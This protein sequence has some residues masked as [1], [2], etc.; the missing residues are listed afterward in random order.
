M[1]DPDNFPRICS[2]GYEEAVVPGW[3]IVEFPALSNTRTLAVIPDYQIVLIMKHILLVFFFFFSSYAF[4]QKVVLATY[5]YADNN[6]LE[7]IKP[8]ASFLSDSLGF[9]IEIKSY[10]TVHAFIEGIQ[11][12][13]VDIAL[14]NTFGYLLFET[15]NQKSRM[16]P[17]AVLKVKDGAENNYKTAFLA[18]MDFPIDTITGLKKVASNFEL[19]LVAIG[20]TSGNLVP[21]LIM[22]SIGIETPENVFKTV[23]YCGNHKNA[24]DLLLAGNIDICAVG[25]TEYFSAMADSSKSRHIKL[26]WLS[27]EIPL[28]P[29]LLHERLSNPMKEKIVAFLLNLDKSSHDTLEA[30]KAGWS[31]AKQAETFIRIDRRYYD[32]FRGQFSNK[33]AMERILTQFAN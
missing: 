24:V 19:G 3:A 4:A 30:I 14:I 5:Q 31:E 28:G 20:S 23:E 18:R 6:R 15:S 25:S 17:H 7:N 9:D 21:R 12:D 8:L 32:P 16:E 26:L 13:E 27:S 33:M 22:S 29:V 1:C 2:F 11:R 10:P